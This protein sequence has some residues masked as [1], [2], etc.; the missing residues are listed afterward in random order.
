MTRAYA[1]DTAARLS[2]VGYVGIVL[3]HLLG[4]AL[5]GE[6]PGPAQTAGAVLVIG[7]GLLL[8]AAALRDARR[9]PRAAGSPAAT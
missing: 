5:L 3:T 2:A 1:L 8:A 6:E 7:A 4:V 9:A